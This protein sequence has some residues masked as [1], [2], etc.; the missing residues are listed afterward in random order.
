MHMVTTRKLVLVVTIRKLVLVATT[1]KL[2]FEVT[3]HYMPAPCGYICMLL[4]MV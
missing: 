4:W 1:R 3:V 2:V